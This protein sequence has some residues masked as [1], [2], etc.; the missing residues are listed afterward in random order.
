M[1]H[2]CV[3]LEPGGVCPSSVGRISQGGS[4]VT[5]GL[6]PQPPPR[7]TEI[8][9]DTAL[10]VLQYISPLNTQ[11]E[12]SLRQQKPR[13]KRNTN[14]CFDLDSNLGLSLLV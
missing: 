2:I 14:Y 11:L 1:S 7:G 9:S 8:I 4:K 5:L 3:T 10:V 13:S 12:I 6:L